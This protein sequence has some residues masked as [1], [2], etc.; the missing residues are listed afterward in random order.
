MSEKGKTTQS[1]ILNLN[2]NYANSKA[3]D[4]LQPVAQ[5]LDIGKNAEVS[6]YNCNLTRKPIFIE[7]NTPAPH[8]GECN[9][10][11]DMN[12]FPSNEQL[13]QIGIDSDIID[14][15]YL[16]D[17]VFT[18]PDED[19][20]DV[21]FNIKS[22]G[23]TVDEFGVRI[24]QA[25]NTIIT[26]GLDG[27]QI[28]IGEGENDMTIGGTECVTS[29]PYQYIYDRE[30]F[31]MGLVGKPYTPYN[32]STGDGNILYSSINNCQDLNIEGT[33]NNEYLKTANMNIQR[34]SAGVLRGVRKITSNA[35][36]THTTYE[37]F[38]R[39]SDSPIFP[40]FKLDNPDLQ[41]NNYQQSQSFFEFDIEI[42]SSNSYNFDMVM[43]FTNT[44]L[45][46]HWANSNVPEE[47][48][49]Y[50]SGD[51]V[52]Q[53]LVGARFI[54]SKTGGNV[55]ESKIDIF[56]PTILTHK[57][58][59]LSNGDILND[60]FSQGLQKLTTIDLETDNIGFG[61]LNTQGKF[62]FRF[63]AHTNQSNPYKVLENQVAGFNANANDKIFE[64]VYSFQFYGK[65]L[66]DTDR[67]L[68]DS[69]KA[70]VYFPANLIETGF[71]AN[72]VKSERGGDERVM[73]GFIPYMFVKKMNA[74]DGI[75]N[76]R[77]NFI[78]Q[79]DFARNKIGYRLGI[80]YYTYKIK[81]TTLN[82]VLGLEK[83][84]PLGSLSYKLYTIQDKSEYKK[85]NYNK[86]KRFD[87]NAYPQYLA[88][89]GLTRLYSDNTKY[90]IELN[91][92]IRGYNTTKPT[93]INSNN[94]RISN[95]G[96]KRAIVYQTPPLI[97]GETNGLNQT[98]INVFK[99]PNN[100]KYLTL[101][102][103]KKLNINELNVQ[104]RRSDTN[105]LATE[106]EDCSVELL[107]TSEN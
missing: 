36:V 61:G 18:D 29:F 51:S 69:A 40:L 1:V 78:L 52:P 74:G 10:V 71:L 41:N 53:V 105:E 37:D 47:N 72:C 99:E 92:P 79:K 45:Q 82:N 103:D 7:G 63:V 95:L 57:L 65:L 87:A 5:Q 34:E 24:S 75:T 88:D 68:Y 83:E 58:N 35:T 26:Q 13:F 42:D 85:I 56:V 107:I 90:N 30:P 2:K 77:G 39:I 76:P 91:L 20:S 93:K 62:G 33:D 89:G 49:L 28:F 27:L 100:L 6:L 14:E 97:D 12:Y 54:E 44:Y 4:F 3:H 50:P 98:F 48:T 16:L 96:Q 102:N 55:T 59:I 9:F 84:P 31:Y 21:D 64:R 73:F 15:S 8:T 66:G 43:G 46:S 32:E 38:S 86:L 11:I 94:V 23:Y 101:N 81:N 17:L 104:I 22:D 67:V 80:D 70:N 106:L 60:I 25:V 19:I